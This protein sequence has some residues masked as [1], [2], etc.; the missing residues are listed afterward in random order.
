MDDGVAPTVTE[1]T[2][3]AGAD[4]TVSV[5]DP[6][7]LVSALAVAE[8]WA[9]PAATLVI[10]PVDAST[11]ATDVVSEEKFPQFPLVVPSL[12]VTVHVAF[13]VAPA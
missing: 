13:A 6:D 4:V 12:I 1:V 5:A 8:M 10:A 9:V 3:G 2:V 7:T 11:V